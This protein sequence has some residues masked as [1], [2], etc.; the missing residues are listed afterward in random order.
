MSNI[1]ILT[2]STLYNMRVKVER[3]NVHKILVGKPE[4]E[5]PL[6]T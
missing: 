4:R 6:E 1:Y 2:A 5:K 3:R